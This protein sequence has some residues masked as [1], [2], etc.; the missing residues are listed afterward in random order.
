MSLNFFFFGFV[1]SS[2]LCAGFLWLRWVGTTLHCSAR[3]SS[4]SGFSWCRAWALGAQAS[5]DAATQAQELWHMGLCVPWH[6]N[7][8]GPGI[9]PTSPA[10]SVGFL[11]TIP[12]GKF[13]MLF[14]KKLPVACYIDPEYIL[15]SGGYWVHDHEIPVSIINLILSNYTQSKA[16]AHHNQVEET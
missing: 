6:V 15:I 7:L 13:Y 8:P 11:F 2:F 14:L 5:V 1:G 3:A 16:S 4:C 10:L 12:R 9:K